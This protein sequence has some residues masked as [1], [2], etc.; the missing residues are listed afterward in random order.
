MAEVP[1]GTGVHAGH[2]GPVALACLAEGLGVL[3]LLR[4][5]AVH[6]QGPGL[7]R[8]ALG[9]EESVDRSP[10]I[11]QA[12]VE[13]EYSLSAAKPVVSASVI[14]IVSASPASLQRS[15]A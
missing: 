5:D 10:A 12:D 15:S 14:M 8:D 4:R 11:A 2:Q 9:L 13:L 6:L 3:V 1:A 7:G